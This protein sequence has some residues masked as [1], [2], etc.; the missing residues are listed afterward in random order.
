MGRL[1][2]SSLLLDFS[3]PN[4]AMPPTPIFH[5]HWSSKT[6]PESRAR[7]PNQAMPPTPIFHCHWSAKTKPAIEK[8]VHADPTKQ[9]PPPQCST[10]AGQR[11]CASTPF[12]QIFH[13][14]WSVSENQTGN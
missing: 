3:R 9:R 12:Q 5:C 14:G 8:A 4:Q 13:L 1:R 6:K 7:R 11:K 10:T 2:P